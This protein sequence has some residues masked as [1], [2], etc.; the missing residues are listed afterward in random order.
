M[1]KCP[2]LT[3]HFRSIDIVKCLPRTSQYGI[4]TIH[5]GRNNAVARHYAV[6]NDQKLAHSVTRTLSDGYKS[7][8]SL[9]QLS[10]RN[11]QQEIGKRE[12]EAGALQDAQSTLSLLMSNPFN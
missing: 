12:K 3:L 5:K 9:T 11:H 2:E 6:Q 8:L 10:L 4:D 1:D 7:L